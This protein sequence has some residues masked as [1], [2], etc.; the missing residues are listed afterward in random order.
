[1]TTSNHLWTAS[2]ATQYEFKTRR[3]PHLRPTLSSAMLR[4]FRVALFL[5]M[6]WWHGL[7]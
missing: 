1:M 7:P 5:L 6:P 4:R 3:P 2:C